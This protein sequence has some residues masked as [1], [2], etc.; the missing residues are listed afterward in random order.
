MNE[1]EMSRK[2][3]SRIDAEMAKLFEQRMKAAEKIAE[4]KKECGLSIRDYAREA[5]LINRSRR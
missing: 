1:L 3:I 2:E 4:Y 5:E